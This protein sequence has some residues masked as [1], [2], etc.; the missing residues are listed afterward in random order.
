VLG[1][2]PPISFA[3][4]AAAAVPG[5]ALGNFSWD[6]IYRSYATRDARFAAHAER[7]ADAYRR[8]DLLLRLP[9][10]GE[11]S[12]FRRI[13]DLPLVARRSELS[14]SEARAAL[15]L[16]SAGPIVLLSFGGLGFGDF[17]AGKLGKIGAVR[18][19][20]TERY[21]GTASNLVTFAESDLDYTTFLRASDAVI[22][23]PGFGIVAACLA[24]GVRVLY[25]SR[26]E[27]P[28]YPILVEALERH[29]TARF[30]A[31]EALRH[32]DF[33][34]PLEE[35]LSKLVRASDLPANGAEVAAS[36]IEEW[37]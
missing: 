12:A 2:V 6:W 27:F 1:D 15:G 14:Q 18:F 32:G 7:A 25:T 33:R 36:V 31:P 20:A 35:L 34:E 10:H 23:K 30:V 9:F 11:M 4:A 22:S 29:G 37:L 8:A 28:E 21:V 16:P 26:G 19:L 24:N 13:E 3:A 5:L 17:D